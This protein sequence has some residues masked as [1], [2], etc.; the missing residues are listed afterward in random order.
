[1]SKIEVA[2]HCSFLNA[3]LT[4][5]SALLKEYAVTKVHWNCCGFLETF[6]NQIVALLF[7]HRNF[8]GDF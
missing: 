3:G 5:A 1:M 6:T 7:S 4:P 8:S 2:Q